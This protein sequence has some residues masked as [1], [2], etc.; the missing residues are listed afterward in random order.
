M[1]HTSRST[2]FLLLLVL[3]PVLLACSDS[4]PNAGTNGSPSEPAAATDVPR[5]QVRL[6]APRS[7]TPDAPAQAAPRVP[8]ASDPKVSEDLEKG[9]DVMVRRGDLVG[10]V[11]RYA[12][13]VSE[14]RKLHVAHPEDSSLLALLVRRLNKAAYSCR[15]ANRTEEA[16]VLYR[17]H[18]KFAQTLSGRGA[19]RVAAATDA[20]RSLQILGDLLLQAGRA[21]AALSSFHAAL[22]RMERAEP[23]VKLTP[24]HRRNLS[25]ALGRIGFA[26]Q[27]LKRFDEGRTQLQRSVKLAAELAAAPQN[28]RDPSSAIEYAGAL[29]GLAALEMAAGAK[30]AA[31]GHL[32][33]ALNVHR[34]LVSA[35]SGTAP[36]LRHGLSVAAARLARVELEREKIDSARRLAQE[37]LRALEQ[38]IPMASNEAGALREKVARLELL[39][40]VELAAKSWDAAAKHRVEALAVLEGLVEQSGGAALLW[41]QCARVHVALKALHDQAVASPDVDDAARKEH[42]NQAQF[43]RDRALQAARQAADRD[44]ALSA[45]AAQLASELAGSQGRATIGD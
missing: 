3:A 17:E 8:T 33:G 23:S 25:V 40:D 18:V 16:I 9:G 10:A 24:D 34:Q 12:R 36:E 31:R 41:M 4:S 1:L 39:S 27:K 5:A 22:E 15:L 43:H 19:D 14:T 21:E 11:A 2:P 30:D 28:T 32:E 6:E 26:L 35:P 44:G 42:E 37:S 20:L 45:W 7:T 38:V 29:T 13:S